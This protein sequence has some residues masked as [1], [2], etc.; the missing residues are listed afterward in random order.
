MMQNISNPLPLSTNNNLARN[1]T[2]TLDNE[3]NKQT[4]TQLLN[5][6]DN[7]GIYLS[8]RDVKATTTRVGYQDNRDQAHKMI[9]EMPWTLENMVKRPCFIKTLDWSVS[10]PALT[11]LARLRVPE[12]LLTQDI[13]QA[14]FRNF[15]FWRGEPELNLQV[16][17]T[18]LHQGLLAAFFVPLTASDKI[19][20]DIASNRASF[21]IN[22]CVYLSANTNTSAVM[23]IPFNHIQGYIDLTNPDD[24]I[25]VKSMGYIYVVVMNQLAAAAASTTTVS[26]S[27][28]SRFLNSEFKVPRFLKPQGNSTSIIN[29]WKNV[30]GATMPISTKGDDIDL[31]LEI[32]GLDKPNIPMA[33]G[34]VLP[35]SHNFMNFSTGFEFN[36]KL[37]IESCGQ[38]LTTT[39]TFA[40]DMDEM[41]MDFL[42]RKF[43]YL[44]TVTFDGRLTP[45]SIID[46]WSISPFP[47]QSKMLINKNLEVPLLTYISYP[48]EFWRGGITFKFQVVATSFQTGKLFFAIN[49]GSVVP[50]TDLAQ[51]TSQYGAAFELN[52]GTNEFEYTIPYV[53]L[54]SFKKIPNSTALTLNSCLGCCS[55]LVLQPLVS[56]NNT[57]TSIEINVYVA[58]GDDFELHTIGMSNNII[59]VFNPPPASKLLK[60]Q[61]SVA[62]MNSEQSDV[63]L[64][65]NEH[66]LSPTQNISKVENIQFG[67]YTRSI[68]DILKKYQPIHIVTKHSDNG[69]EVITGLSTTTTT[70]FPMDSTYI[71][72]K[73]SADTNQGFNGL[74]TWGS[75]LYR[76]YRGGFRIKAIFETIG[77]LQPLGS[78]LEFP[79]SIFWTP[80]TQAVTDDFKTYYN[81]VRDVPQVLFGLPADSKNVDLIRLPLVVNNSTFRSCEFEVPFTTQYQSLLIPNSNLTENYLLGPSP[82]SNCGTLVFVPNFVDST[83]LANTYTTDF[84]LRLY[85]ALSDETR[86]GTLFQVPRI[87]INTC[88]GASI[89]PDYYLPA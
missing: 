76:Q 73:P 89:P 72:R 51:A 23:N 66:I 18:P 32:P 70:I 82:I 64:S 20:V 61:S 65:K 75:S 69:I 58:G 42:K 27:L 50:S 17:A 16:T 11:V 37:Q 87:R 52:Q 29:N 12:D 9:S 28:F 4:T 6:N 25:Q 24:N 39:E 31:G 14:P 57:P 8:T 62:P 47:L 49:F 55:L 88:N 83:P 63:N 3:N 71:L 78:N 35:R 53:A 54:T 74:I 44:S 46:T 84:K 48:F 33:T 2:T 80:N 15:V 10:Q 85:V 45:G 86:F 5:S 21:S 81:S 22:Q 1:I 41:A 40:T 79:Y 34:V 60:P 43:S 56:P 59:P 67:S 19:D 38:A 13:V 36:D 26:V 68:R 7:L 77:G 30:A